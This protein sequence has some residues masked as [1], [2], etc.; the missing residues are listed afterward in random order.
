MKV[1]NLLTDVRVYFEKE[2]RH[3][4]HKI[5]KI[6]I[7]YCKFKKYF[8]L[9]DHE[10]KKQLKR[11]LETKIRSANKYRI[12]T[13][14][15]EL[16]HEDLSVKQPKKSYLH[17]ALYEVCENSTTLDIKDYFQHLGEYEKEEYHRYNGFDEKPNLPF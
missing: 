12:D 8:P 15:Y 11:K 2:P 10:K 3:V 4:R 5:L 17:K 6:M 16:D 7:E 9:P 1:P 14:Y 13:S